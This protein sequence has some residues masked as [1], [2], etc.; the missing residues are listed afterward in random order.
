MPYGSIQ[1]NNTDNGK[2]L[3]NLKQQDYRSP[4][5]HASNWDLIETILCSVIIVVLDWVKDQVQI[6]R[7]RT[8]TGDIYKW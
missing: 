3:L 2:G 6:L 1:T 4:S 8:R 7:V 5:A